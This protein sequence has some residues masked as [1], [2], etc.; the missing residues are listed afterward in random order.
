MKN[1]RYLALVAA[2]VTAL[3]AAPL[4]AV[5]QRLE[6]DELAALQ[7]K[8]ATPE[9]HLRLAAHFVAEAEDFEQDAARHE[10]MGKRYSR[11]NLPPKIVSLNRSMVRHCRNLSRSLREAAKE[12]RQ[13]A[14]NHKA[15]AAESGK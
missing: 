8:E 6:A 4:W 11:P 1:F 3:A 5:P 13:L 7:A 12:A 10:A 15:M 9:D 14:E 2:F